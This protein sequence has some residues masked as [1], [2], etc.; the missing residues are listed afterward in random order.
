MSDSSTLGIPVLVLGMSAVLVYGWKKEGT[1]HGP[2]A[3]ARL[4]EVAARA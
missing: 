4:P 1:L 3:L 2:E